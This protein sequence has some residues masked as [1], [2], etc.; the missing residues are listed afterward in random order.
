MPGNV[1]ACATSRLETGIPQARAH[2][3][4]GG[5]V[6]ALVL[7]SLV[8]CAPKSATTPTTSSD[9]L[10]WR[11]L[12]PTLACDDEGNVYVAASEQFETHAEIFVA[13]SNRYG[14]EWNTQ[15]HYVNRSR[16]GDR[17]RP[18][19]ATGAP[20]EVFVLWEDT[21]DGRV[22]LYLNRSLD[23]GRTWRDADVRVDVGAHPSRRVAHPALQ[24]DDRGNVYALWRDDREGFDAFYFASSA[25]RGASWSMQPARINR[26][27]PGRKSAP[28]LALDEDGNVY[29]AWIQ[30]DGGQPA[31]YFNTSSNQGRTWLYEEVR[32]SRG[33]GVTLMSLPQLCA[34]RSGAVLVTWLELRDGRAEVRLTRSPDRGQGWDPQPSILA[35]AGGPY[36]NPSPPQISCDLHGHVYVA[37]QVQTSDGGPIFVV[38]SSDDSGR[39]FIETRFPGSGVGRVPEIDLFAE[40]RATPFRMATD[41]TGN[42]YIAWLSGTAGR[43]DVGFDRVSNYGRTW[44]GLA[45]AVGTPGHVPHG[46][47]APLI[48]A[49]SFGHVYLLWSDGATLTAAA[50]PFYG[51]SGWRYEHF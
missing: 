48:C 44:L 5:C 32:L 43:P 16:L 33:G 6:G 17:G 22:G 26:A 1:P 4:Q 38:K 42:V 23:G 25:D 49:D 50:S 20:G 36:F 45:R 15:F 47:E 28:T 21:R 24:C 7:A 14:E 8:A 12:D 51:D 34:N 41:E 31:L 30:L 29:V 3:S 13:A 11:F 10:V 9:A 46:P 27:D 40:P 18:L 35:A 39:N 19:L 37:W 2:R